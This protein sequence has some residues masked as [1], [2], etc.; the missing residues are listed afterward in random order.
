MI[1]F[2]SDRLFNP[3]TGSLSSFAL[4]KQPCQKIHPVVKEK[5]VCF[6]QSKGNSRDLGLVLRKPLVSEANRRF[7][8]LPCS[9]VMGASG[10]EK[11]QL[12]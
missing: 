7:H 6:T 11:K 2:V 4:G 10:K 3:N 9:P 12:K 8:D 5:M 1:M